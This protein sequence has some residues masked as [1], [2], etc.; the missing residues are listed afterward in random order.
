MRCPNCGA[1]VGIIDGGVK[2][3][4]YRGDNGDPICKNCG[5]GKYPNAQRNLLITTIILVVIA[6]IASVIFN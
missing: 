2:K 6:V 1:E 3:Y 4:F 5:A